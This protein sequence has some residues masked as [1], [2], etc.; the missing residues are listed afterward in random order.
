MAVPATRGRMK[1]VVG[2]GPFRASQDVLL[3]RGPGSY[4]VG[5]RLPHTDGA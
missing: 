3:P 4:T 1:S 5:L 2:A